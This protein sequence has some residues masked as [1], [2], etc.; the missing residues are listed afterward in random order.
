M[1]KAE[2]SV[3]S[4]LGGIRTGSQSHHGGEDLL[5]MLTFI[6][7]LFCRHM[8]QSSFSTLTFDMGSELVGDHPV[9]QDSKGAA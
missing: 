4:G 2:L 7:G 5:N 8:S 1:V 9:V 3:G 6:L